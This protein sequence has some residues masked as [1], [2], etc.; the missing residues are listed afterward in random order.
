M[1]FARLLLPVV[2]AALLL[3]LAP[4]LFAQTKALKKIRVGV[5]AVSM[6]NMII[7]FA[8]EARL[9]GGVGEKRFHKEAV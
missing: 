6:G 2:L 3:A 8:K 4:P 1:S 5:P 9:F 7:F